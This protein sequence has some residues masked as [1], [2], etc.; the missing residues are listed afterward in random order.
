MSR[1]QK[2][3][4]SD[5]SEAE[6]VDTLT[7]ALFG[8]DVPRDA[9]RAKTRRGSTPKRLSFSKR[10]FESALKGATER[11]AITA[12][13]FPPEIVKDLKKP[14]AEAVLSSMSPDCD[15]ELDDDRRVW[16]LG[17][18]RRRSALARL[19]EGKRSRLLSLLR[20]APAYEWD[21]VGGYLQSL[22]RNGVPVQQP[23]SL[24]KMRALAQAYDW[25]SGI[26]DIKGADQALRQAIGFR[27]LLNEKRSLLK[28]GVF[29]R[30]D[31]RA[32]F[33]SFLRAELPPSGQ[34]PPVLTVSGV[35]G[36]GKST[37]LAVVT[38]DLVQRRHKGAP[39]VFHIDFDRFG[40][41]PNSLIELTFEITRQIA[42][43]EPATM[44]ELL[45]MT[46]G[47]ETRRLYL[48]EAS[49]K[50][51][52][53]LMGRMRAAT[54]SHGWQSRDAVLVLDTFEELQAK[55]AD[56]AF[57]E[58]SGVYATDQIA[59]WIRQLVVD[60]GLKQL[61][62]VISGRAPVDTHSRLA[63]YVVGD[64]VLH[65]LEQDDAIQLLIRAGL[66]AS[67]APQLQE[68]VGGNPL[69]LRIAARYM[70]KLPRNKRTA[71]LR[72]LASSSAFVNQELVQEVLYERIL[73][74]VRDHKAR[75]LAH[76]GLVLRRVTPQLIRNVLAEPCDLG[77]VDEAEA[78]RLFEAL[79]DEVWLVERDPR[80]ADVLVHRSDVRRMMLQL[81]TKDNTL[82]SEG[83]SGSVP[84]R[85]RGAVV[86]EI[87]NRAF[88]YYTRRIDPD[89][90]V[91]TADAEAFYHRMM[92]IDETTVRDVSRANVRQIVGAF[93]GDVDLLTPSLRLR[94][95]QLIGEPLSLDE[96]VLLPED[97]WF[98][99][100]YRE[101]L[102]RLDGRQE[103]LAA[104]ALIER[105]AVAAPDTAPEWQLRALDAAARWDTLSEEWL[106]QVRMPRSLPSDVSE[107]RANHS[108]SKALLLMRRG[109]YAAAVAVVDDVLIEMRNAVSRMAREQGKLA[110][111]LR[112]ANYSLLARAA[113][114][115]TEYPQKRTLGPPIQ[116]DWPFAQLPRTID[117]PG[118]DLELRR[119]VALTWR[120][121]VP[122]PV[123]MRLTAHA[124]VPDA[125]WL[126]AV[127][128]LTEKSILPPEVAG[129]R[130]G[131]SVAEILGRIATEFAQNL[132]RKLGDGLLTTAARHD[133]DPMLFCGDDP[134]MRP[135]AKYALREAFPTYRDLRRLAELTPQHLPI[136]PSDLQ[137]DV[138]ANAD[139]LPAHAISLLVEYADRSRVLAK[140]LA[141][142][143]QERP[144]SELLQKVSKS[145][146]RWKAMF[147]EEVTKNRTKGPR[148]VALVTLEA[149]N[150]L[151]GD[152]LLLRYQGPDHKERLW[153]IDGG[154]KSETVNGKKVAVWK[155][156]LLPRLKQIDPTRPLP[157]ALG[158]V[159]HID[160]DHINGV[161]KLTSTLVAAR[162]SQ[163]AAVRFSRFWFNSF[164]KLV[165][166]KPAGLS[167]EAATASLQS[168]I[169]EVLPEVVDE[170]A[171]LIM[172]SV[173]QGNLL[174]ADIRTLRLNDNQPINGVV[175]ARKGQQ[176]IS[177]EGANVTVIG[178][179]ES[180]VEALRKAWAQALKKPT[181]KA[182]QAAL[183]KLFLPKKSLDES[184]PNLASI[185]VLVEVSGRK[186][187]L[188]G[189]AHGDDMVEAWKKLELGAGP[190]SIDL[191]KMPNHGSIRNTTKAFLEFFVADHYVFSANGKYN[192]PDAP[193][194]E[195][196]VKMHGNRK[197]VL[198]FTNEDVTW[199]QPYRLEKDKTKV[200][201]LDQMLIAL[202][203]AYPGP[204]TANLRKPDDKSVVVKLA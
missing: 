80:R 148:N 144:A 182:R 54:A 24:R 26:R 193:T 192:N 4:L 125:A 95:R 179:L 116:V 11:A 141:A 22:L 135:A 51:L 96:A 123:Q 191:L 183:Q 73:Q 36:S 101:G 60:G 146:T 45:S 92:L 63:R 185:V 111:H 130:N 42:L 177:I 91:T 14:V 23:S 153:I 88:D 13:F 186:L 41:G 74:H 136:V 86:R 121:G 27:S 37:F 168:L 137:P 204:W 33:D 150:A 176:K 102:A 190:V 81:M 196:V 55:R 132:A 143:A 66:T 161:Q 1:P 172:Q 105:R 126:Q 120:A 56:P 89:D 34:C 40:L 100:A 159:S 16:I 202:H 87:H 139:R 108:A 82:A 17:R 199:G 154:P 178:P 3:A 99:Y 20:R 118:L 32:K 171:T 200:R 49:L 189:D 71:F 48:Q 21:D 149:L 31:A 166:P 134:E 38:R 7:Q 15:V 18:E 103:P 151:Y 70:R 162:P 61:R 93:G 197:I 68:V 160:D 194:L 113:H 85:T 19:N 152:C 9:S 128:D 184:V 131:A 180:R 6:L 59:N 53:D 72:D 174:A 140:V 112:C 65:D 107:S 39:A 163:P 173:D 164:D 47:T 106:E 165:G 170:L 77:D 50:F 122:L 94:V 30:K 147:T 201:N 181:R 167:G 69:A 156:V 110:E 203:A 78:K 97:D 46:L 62:V 35:G 83:A 52:S 5:R 157:I 29:G 58:S 104:L 2:T 28:N 127:E 158:M 187:L 25:V 64:I 44:R 90:D 76:P 98:S 145:T 115:R 129:L 124:F 43:Y 57:T 142:A 79:A 10:D 133:F 155:D 114:N 188:T 119:N 195:A 198:H 109:E 12:R 84:V 67:A 8:A 169:D 138:F 117:H 75:K 175:M